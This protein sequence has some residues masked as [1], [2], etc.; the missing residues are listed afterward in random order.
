[1]GPVRGGGREVGQRMPS[2]GQ[3]VTAASWP[4]GNCTGEEGGGMCVHTCTLVY[5]GTFQFRWKAY[6][7][8]C[9]CTLCYIHV[10]M[11]M[12][13]FYLYICTCHGGA[14]QAIAAVSSLLALIGGEY[15][16]GTPPTRLYIQKL[17]HDPV[18]LC[19]YMYIITKCRAS[20]CIDQ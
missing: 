19:I 1:M 18:T 7:Y 4:H 2:L 17:N 11:Y 12:Y 5:I 14:R 6:M 13:T 20:V 8:T 15:L 16:L 9:T 10:Y 3:P